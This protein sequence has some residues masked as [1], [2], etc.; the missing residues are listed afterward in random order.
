[1]CACTAVL[2]Q[3]TSTTIHNKMYVLPGRCSEGSTAMFLDAYPWKLTYFE[4]MLS[5]DTVATGVLFHCLPN[6]I[7]A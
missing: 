1:M 4:P 6:S 7:R 3:L 2:H 5:S